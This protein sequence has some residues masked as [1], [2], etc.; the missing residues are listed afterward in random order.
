[1]IAMDRLPV[2]KRSVLQKS[3]KYCAAA[4]IC[5]SLTIFMLSVVEFLVNPSSVAGVVVACTGVVL[6]SC[7][8]FLFARYSQALKEEAGSRS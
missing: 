5:L 1:M 7:T 4:L 6:M 3:D 8:I 2:D